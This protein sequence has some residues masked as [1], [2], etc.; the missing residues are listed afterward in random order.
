MSGR[1]RGSEFII[2]DV[3]GI[4][5]KDH[6]VSAKMWDLRFTVNVPTYLDI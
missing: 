4:V 6:D 2:D 5:L 3:S 1:R